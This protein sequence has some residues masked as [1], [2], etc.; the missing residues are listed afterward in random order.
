MIT[1]QKFNIKNIK[2]EEYKLLDYLPIG[3]FIITQNMMVIFWNKCLENWTNIAREDILYKKINEYFPHFNKPKYYQRI[4][5]IFK[6]SP[7]T[8]FSS[9]LHQYLIPSPLG[10]DRF[11]KQN[12]MVIP[13][14][15]LDDNNYDALFAIQ[16]VTEANHLIKEYREIR[17]LA[18][19]ELDY[20][21]QIEQLLL[22]KTHE[23][24]KK[25]IE[26]TTLYQMTITD[27]LTGLYNRRYLDQLLE[28]T[29]L[30]AKKNNLIFSV[31]ML[32]LDHF[33]NINDTFSH[34]AG[35]LVLVTVAN[36]LQGN[37]RKTD[38]VFRYGGEE[39]TLILPN[40]SLID[41]YKKAEEIRITIKQLGILYQE[42]F[43]INLTA[44]FG[45]ACFPEHGLTSQ[46]I[47]C[48]AD[49][50]LYQAKESG[51]DRVIIAS[52]TK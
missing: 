25:N 46:E 43:L 28:E 42:K 9:H 8:I 20:R 13:I 11:R 33:K 38:F 32:D 34:D 19:K 3:I 1:E 35:D 45:V 52:T 36:L 48:A 10:K 14:P 5:D 17:D 40:V 18:I 37:T 6:G 16:D 2:S 21:K 49:A 30:L 22:I 12:T 47:L 31:I 44:S 39:L 15:H 50:A 26:L 7:P 24:E 29:L 23:L 4:K 51:R 27:P 41:T